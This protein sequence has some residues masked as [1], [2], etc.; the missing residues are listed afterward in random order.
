MSTAINIGVGEASAVTDAGD[1]QLDKGVLNT[2]A[3]VFMVLAVSAPLAVVVA[4]LPIALAFGNG[5]GVP[6]A[7]LLATAAMMLF[8]VGY[9]R[10]IPF[11]KNAGAF[12]A[13]I[14]ASVGRVIGLPAAYVAAVSYMALCVSTMSALAFFSGDLF[15]RATGIPTSWPLWAAIN[16]VLIVTLAYH[17]ITLVAKVL[18]FVLIAEVVAVMALNIA[19]MIRNGLPA[20]NPG[21]FSPSTVFAPGLGIALI[22]AFNSTIGFEGTAIY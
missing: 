14:S 6:G 21:D 3:I 9:V 20:F 8:A 16:T 22:Y 17:R 11:V 13:Y 10:Q 12:Y 7:F 4:L 18:A 19:I 1:E 5:A 15:T 2:S